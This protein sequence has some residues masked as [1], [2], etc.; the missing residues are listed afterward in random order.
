LDLI[1]QE[2][3]CRMIGSQFTFMP[4][5]QTDVPHALIRDS[6]TFF[7][8]TFNPFHQGHLSC[9][10]LCPEKNIVV[11][12]DRNPQK[13]VRNFLPYEE[14]LLILEQLSG[15]P[16]YVYPG[17][18]A[19]HNANPTY[20][21]LPY[22]KIPEKNFLMGDDTFMNFLSWQ[23]PDVILNALTKLYVVPRNFHEKKHLNEL[24]IQRIKLNEI[25]P[26]LQIIFLGDHDYK[27][28]SS[29]EIR[30]SHILK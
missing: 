10:E 28:L 29:T 14:Y 21:W 6:V 13:D 16:Y 24:E 22:V 23:F 27:N 2:E 8:G 30:R 26:K 3:Q 15:R 4:L 1:E 18:W 7:G 11:I 17:F 25:N 5:S 9:L 19:N 12:P 20:T